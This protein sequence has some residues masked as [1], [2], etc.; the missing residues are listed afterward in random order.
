M[1]VIAPIVD[2]A[3][4]WWIFDWLGVTGLTL[5]VGAVC[6]GLIS[7]ILIQPLMVPQRLVMWRLA[8]ETILRRKRQAALLVTG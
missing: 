2:S 4:A 7:H 5:W 1:L 6:I 8:K 3:I